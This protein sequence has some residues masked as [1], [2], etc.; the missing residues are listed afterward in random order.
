MSGSD[1]TFHRRRPGVGWLLALF[2]VSLLLALIGCGATDGSAENA[3][4]A[5]PSVDPSDGA[6]TAEA[7]GPLGAMS[8]TRTGNGFSLAGELP[9]EGLKSSLPESIRQAMPGAKVVDD[10]T[11]KPGV[12]APEFAGLGAL[13]GAALDIP[14]FGANLVGDTVTLT[15]TAGSE[16]VKAAAETA[17]K[18]T[19]P[20]V[21]VVN[22]IQV[23]ASAAAPA[24]AG[25]CSTVQADITGL[26]KTP[27]NFATDE[28]ALNPNSQRLVGQIAEKVKAC[29]GVNVAVVGYTDDSGGDAINVPLSTSRAKAVADAL[30]SD[31]VAGP[32]RNRRVEITVG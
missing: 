8:I 26:L 1:C 7:G 27:I 3:D 32:A 17:A 9:D 23:T 15:G 18:A 5:V 19:W 10:L 24:P 13:F 25:A 12:K 22:D 4:L 28:F 21:M 2:A 14:G 20:K 29:P 31:G 30:V 6:P 16:E 11:V